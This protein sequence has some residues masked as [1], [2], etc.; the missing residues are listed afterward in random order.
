MKAIE[1]RQDILAKLV[2]MG[3][4]EGDPTLLKISGLIE[5]EGLLKA[6]AQTFSTTSTNGVNHA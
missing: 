5:A 1:D 3:F 6:L 4:Q 2:S